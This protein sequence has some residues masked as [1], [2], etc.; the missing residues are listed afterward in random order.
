MVTLIS[1]ILRKAERVESESQVFQVLL[2]KTEVIFV[3]GS[4]A[5]MFALM[6]G[7]N[8]DAQLGSQMPE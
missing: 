7:V 3:E 1:L 5:Q 2:Y 4:E 8:R 6:I